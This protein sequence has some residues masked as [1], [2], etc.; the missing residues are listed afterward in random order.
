M[1]IIR[2]RTFASLQACFVV[3][4]SSGDVLLRRYTLEIYICC[5]IWLS[6]QWCIILGY[7]VYRIVITVLASYKAE[8]FRAR[9][10][11][12]I[13]IYLLIETRIRFNLLKLHTMHITAHHCRLQSHLVNLFGQNNLDYVVWSCFNPLPLSRAVLRNQIIS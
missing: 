5:Q 2:R 3:S 6:K 12:R 9:G 7:P 8:I 10:N 1:K 13:G 11:L 4:N